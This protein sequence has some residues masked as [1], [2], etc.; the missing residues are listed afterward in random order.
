MARSTVYVITASYNRKKSTAILCE[1]LKKQTYRD[2]VLILVDDKSSDGTIEMVKGYEFRKEVCLGNGKLWWGGGVRRGFARLRALKPKPTDIVIVVN[3]DTILKDDFIERAVAEISQLE[4]KTMLCASVRF[5]DSGRWIDGGTICYWPR[6][7]FKHYRSHPERIDCASTRCLFF[8]FS[9]LSI[10]GTFRPRLLP[11]Y[12]S[13]YEFTIRAR[14]R[15]IKILPSKVT[16]EATEGTTGSH[17]LKPGSI[18][19]VISQIMSPKFSANPFSL[20]YFVLL[21][22]PLSWKPVCWFWALRTIVGFVLKAAIVDRLKKGRRRRRTV[23]R[24]VTSNEA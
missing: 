22:A 8:Q 6:L 24:P 14:K 23:A 18:R 9:N 11:Q 7:T 12:F 5:V 3:D 19:E 20:F 10:A 21:A 1:S 13:D 16:C 4:D 2:F 17:S 15:G